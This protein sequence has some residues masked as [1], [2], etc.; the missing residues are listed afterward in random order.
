MRIIPPSPVT[1]S[2]IA[3]NDHTPMSPNV[4]YAAPFLAPPNEHAA[5]SIKMAFLR[6][7]NSAMS[8][9]QVHSPP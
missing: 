7:A 1:R 4:P 6:L 5:S 3:S 8:E 9:I 2:F